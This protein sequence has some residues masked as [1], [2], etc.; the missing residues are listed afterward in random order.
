MYGGHGCWKF[1]VNEVSRIESD[2]QRQLPA[3][4]YS[5]EEI[6]AGF[7]RLVDKYGIYGTILYLEKETPFNRKELVTWSVYE[8]YVNIRYLADHNEAVKRL[9]EIKK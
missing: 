9:W 3:G 2:H 1:Y 7:K 6:Q 5:S 8:I 4:G